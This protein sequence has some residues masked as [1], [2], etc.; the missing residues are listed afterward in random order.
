MN[1]ILLLVITLLKKVTHSFFFFQ[2]MSSNDTSMKKCKTIRLG[3]CDVLINGL[4]KHLNREGISHALINDFFQ[5]V[6]ISPKFKGVFG[7]WEVKKL[8]KVKSDISKKGT[9]AILIINVGFHFVVILVREKSISY[10]DSFAKNPTKKI[11]NNFLKYFNQP[12][13]KNNYIFQSKKSSFCGLYAC[14]YCIA[15]DM[16]AHERELIQNGYKNHARKIRNFLR[17][18]AITFFEVFND[19]HISR[20]AETKLLRNDTRCVY[21]LKKYARFWST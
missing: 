7:E 13:W 5:L 12:I 11:T 2:S 20:L 14:L 16:I 8:Q 15:F 4:D 21:L 18:N 17:K 1:A 3:E 19:C 6:R 9:P 10:L